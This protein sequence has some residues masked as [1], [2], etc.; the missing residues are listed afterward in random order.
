MISCLTPL[1]AFDLSQ[2]NTVIPAGARLENDSRRVQ[3]GDV[4][5]ACR[6]EYSDGRDYI[7]AALQQ[8]AVAVL[9]DDADGFQWQPSWHVPNLAIPALRAR[10]GVVLAHALHYPSQSLDVVGV[11]G[12]NGKTSITHWLAQAWQAAGHTAAV[13]GTVGNGLW[14][15]LSPATHTTPDPLR[16]QYLLAQYRQAGA[17]AVAMEVSSHGL[18]QYR[19]NGVGFRCAVFTNLTRDHL[20]Y[21][22]DM[23]AYGES[24]RR[25]F[26]WEDLQTAVINQ[27]DAFGQQLLQQ[28][29]P[30][31]C[32]SYGLLGG[33]IRPLAMQMDLSGFQLNI[34]TPWGNTEL[35]SRLLGRFN[36]QNLLACLGVLLSGG[37]PLAQA[38]AALAAIQP[39]QG[40]MQSFGGGEQPLVLVDYAHTPDALEKALSTLA[41]IRPAGGRLWVVFGCGGNRDRGK[42]PLMGEVAGQLADIAVVTSD[43]PRHEDPEQIVQDVVAGMRA[44]RA[45]V[46][47]QVDRRQAIQ[48]AI[49]QAAAGDVVLIAGKGHEDY[50][51]IAGVKTPFSDAE[52][53]RSALNGMASPLDSVEKT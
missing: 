44:A 46:V 21:H 52:E 47:V 2:L 36:V 25:L 31:H 43:N 8:G 37:M 33:D 39:A 49:Q 14:G 6:G 40:R 20:D 35:H 51:E 53:V 11:T 13:I 38:S 28:G 3:A 7:A 24:K 5:V 48:W 1:S 10:I 12:T 17:Q 34:A 16:V 15:Q 41:E 23:Q 19:V 30:A 32:L 4:F 42:R 29:L 18:D 50:Q 22:G 45:E 27:D 9:W 26:Y